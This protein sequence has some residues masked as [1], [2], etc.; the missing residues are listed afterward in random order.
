VTRH[1]GHFDTPQAAYDWA[2]NVFSSGG[3]YLAGLNPAFQC[4]YVMSK[5]GFTFLHLPKGRA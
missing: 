1:L 2:R 3:F 4:F 5:G